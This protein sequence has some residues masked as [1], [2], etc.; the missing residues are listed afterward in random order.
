MSITDIG[1]APARTAEDGPAGTG[2][3]SRPAPAPAGSVGPIFSV[4]GAVE[5]AAGDL[6]ED[7]H[8]ASKIT[9]ITHPGWTDVRYAQQLAQEAQGVADAGPGGATSAPRLLPALALPPALPLPHGLGA[10]MAARRSADPDELAAPLALP[11]LATVLR[12][13]YGPRGGGGTGRFVPSAGGLYPL[14][15]HV[16]VRAA[17]GVA[18]GI[19]Q[20]DP[21]DEALVDVSGL[22]RAGRLARFRRA[23]PTAMA[24]LAEQA[25]VTIVITG[26]FERSR[27]KYGLRGYRLTLLEAGHVAQNALLVATALGLPSIGWVG[28]VDH[29]LDAV[30]GL[31]GVTQSSLYAVSLGG[32]PDPGGTGSGPAAAAAPAPAPA[33]AARRPPDPHAA[34]TGARHFAEEEASHD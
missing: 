5:R 25:A 18:A 26:S 12:L 19:H 27:T 2:A 30:L 31:D 29:E 28:F 15:L 9:R 22:D 21:L 14:D 24:P 34:A 3:E 32:R 10:T 8:E 7:F 16:V 17:E 11:E 20:L 4:G 23:A 33:P 13:A 6:A 1:T